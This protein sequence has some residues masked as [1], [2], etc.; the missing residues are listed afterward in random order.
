MEEGGGGGG[1]GQRLTPELAEST[2]PSRFPS[3]PPMPHES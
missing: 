1:G 3:I 2:S